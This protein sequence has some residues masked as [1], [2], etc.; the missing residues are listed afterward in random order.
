MCN[1]KLS[2]K[3]LPPPPLPFPPLQWRIWVTWLLPINLSLGHLGVVSLMGLITEQKKTLWTNNFKKKKKVDG[4]W[5]ASALCL[6]FVL[7][8]FFSFIQL[9]CH[10]SP[11]MKV[12]SIFQ[13]YFVTYLSQHKKIIYVSVCLSGVSVPENWIILGCWLVWGFFAGGS[14]LC[15]DSCWSWFHV[16]V[17]QSFCPS[18]LQVFL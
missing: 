8:W 1:I 17:L 4:R 2:S 13:V 7:T 12:A 14:V 10:L 6:G 5:F 16:G 11:K 9:S 18:K 3:L 15:F